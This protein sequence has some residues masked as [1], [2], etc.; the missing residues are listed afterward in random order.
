[1]ARRREQAPPPP[2]ALPER[3]RYEDWADEALDGPMPAYWDP[4]ETWMWRKVRAFKRWQT[5]R[6]AARGYRVEADHG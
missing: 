3:F 4:Q 6:L 5:A 1:M 2:D